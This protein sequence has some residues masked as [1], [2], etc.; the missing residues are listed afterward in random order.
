MF[1]VTYEIPVLCPLY[2]LALVGALKGDAIVCHLPKVRQDSK[3]VFKVQRTFSVEVAAILIRE[4]EVF[5]MGL[6]LKNFYWQFA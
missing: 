3:R 1:F 2:L 4:G 6:F 5:E